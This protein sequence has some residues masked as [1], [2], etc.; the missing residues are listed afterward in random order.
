M[1]N[2]FAGGYGGG[3][4]MNSLMK[5]AQKMQ[6]DMLAL[7]NELKE[8]EYTSSSGGGVVTATV[9]GAHELLNLDIKPEAV[10]PEDV[11]MLQDMI[12]AAV[13][14]ALGEAEET[15]AAEMTKLTGSA[16]VPGLF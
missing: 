4:N 7:Q 15:T 8:R 9:N 2:K 14:A 1:A 6:Q 3:M 11:E 10:D 12:L 13:N 5:K 16:S